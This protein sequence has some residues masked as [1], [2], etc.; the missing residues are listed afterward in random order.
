MGHRGSPTIITENTLPSFQKAI[1]QGVDGLEL[2]IRLSKDK[3]IVVYHD[4][5]LKR[6]SNQENRIADLS[7][8][9][10]QTVL[11]SKQEGQ[12]EERHILALNEVA[13]LLD[14]I[15]VI[16]IEIK[17]ESLLKGSAILNPLINFLDRHNIDDKCI[18]SSFNPIIL[19]KLKR[20]RPQTIVGFLYNRKTVL[21]AWKN[22]IWMLR[23]RPE[24]LHIHYS[25][26]DSWIVKWAKKKGLKINAYTINDKKTFLV[27]KKN[28]IDGIFTDNIEYL[29]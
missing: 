18:I 17:S 7:L 9:E 11:L 10:I 22:M 21:H 4:F 12:Q 23:I 8:A 2:D 3:Q 1:D 5:D 27:A 24:N 15:Q 20:R 28:G 26:I 19:T 16:N 6:L 14:Q 25:L 29:K 13:P